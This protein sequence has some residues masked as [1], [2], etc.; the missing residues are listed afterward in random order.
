[1]PT[2]LIAAAEEVRALGADAETA[3][4]PGQKDELGAVRIEQRDVL[5]VVVVVDDDPA[6]REGREMG[7]VAGDAGRRRLSE[8][9]RP[10]ALEELDLAEACELEVLGDGQNVGEGDLHPLARFVE[11]V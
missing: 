8:L 10:A 5:E 6:S 4:G 1:M 9:A 11:G 7:V 2:A 3:V